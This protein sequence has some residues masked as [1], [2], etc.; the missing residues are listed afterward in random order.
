M[1]IEGTNAKFDIAEKPVVDR[2]KQLSEFKELV[3]KK[4]MSLYSL[5]D[6]FKE[7]FKKFSAEQQVKLARF[8]VFSK[9][10]DFY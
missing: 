7:M 2:I 1:I 5:L 9:G 10:P 4:M 8:P 6:E 3:S